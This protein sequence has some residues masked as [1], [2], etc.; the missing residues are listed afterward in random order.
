MKHPEEKN[1][2]KQLIHVW[3][4]LGKRGGMGKGSGRGEKQGREGESGG[5]QKRQVHPVDQFVQVRRMA[6][7]S[8]PSDFLFF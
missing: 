8:S 5:G 1:S 7:V 6:V 2:W 3:Q 4:D